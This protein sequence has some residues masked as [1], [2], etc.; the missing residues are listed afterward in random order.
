MMHLSRFRVLVQ[1]SDPHIVRPGRL[2]EGEIDTAEFLRRAVQSVRALP[3]RPDVV[4]VSGDLVD[5]G[6]EEEYAHLRALLE[7]LGCPLWLMPG[8]HDSAAALRRSFPDHRYLQAGADPGLEPFVLYAQRLGDWHVVAVDTVV[9]GA[10]HGALCARRLRWLEET[11]AAEPDAP[12]VVAMHHP[13][14]RSGIEHMDQIG[15]REGGDELARILSRHSQ[16]RRLICGHLHRPIFS[17]W[18]GVP[19]LTVPST[20]HQIALDWREEGLTAWRSE[21]PGFGVHLL[22]ED[23]HIVSHVAASGD[24]GP[25]HPF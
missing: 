20:A 15:L 13:P 2:L 10:S 8:N 7:P 19:A 16:V 4:L 23:G 9:A 18:G 1:L 17:V 25:A 22:G 24:Y 11:L 21:P 5:A 6:H 3:E 14:F 12:T